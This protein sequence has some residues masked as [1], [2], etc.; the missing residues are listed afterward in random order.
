MRFDKNDSNYKKLIAT[1]EN[2]NVKFFIGAGLSRGSDLPCWEELIKSLAK[3]FSVDASAIEHIG[4]DNNSKGD[5]LQSI[6]DKI[7]EAAK[8]G[9]KKI[10]DEIRSE[11]KKVKPAGGFKVPIQQLVVSIAARTS[12]VVLTT[13][14]DD[15][16]EEAAKKEEI[17][18]KVHFY[19]NI[20]SKEVIGLIKRREKGDGKLHIIHMHGIIAGDKVVLSNKNYEEAY[21]ED[22]TALLTDLNYANI[23]FLGCSFTDPYF[24][25]KYRKEMG[26]GE[27]FAFMPDSTKEFNE[28]IKSQH[29]KPIRYIIDDKNSS[30][31]YNAKL[32]GFLNSLIDELGLYKLKEIR[33]LNDIE[34][35]KSNSS[36]KKCRVLESLKPLKWSFEG[37]SHIKEIECDTAIDYLP[38][39]AFRKC[40]ALKRVVFRGTIKSIADSAF[41]ECVKL[42][43]II[44][45]GK[46]NSFTEVTRI[47]DKAF[48]N[49]KKLIGLDFSV[50]SFSIV[51]KECFFHCDSLKIIE[52]PEYIGRIDERA[53][54]NCKSLIAFR[55]TWYNKLSHIGS[56]A[57]LDC[58]NLEAVVL[59]D[60]INEIEGGAF[61]SCEGI[62][63]LRIPK[64][65]TKVPAFCFHHCTG[66]EAVLNIENSNVTKIETQAFCGCRVLK[67][68]T[69]PASVKAIEKNAFLSCKELAHAYMPP[70]VTVDPDAFPE[71]TKQEKTI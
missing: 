13:N 63:V 12:G 65:L 25:T 41:E 1:L 42:E 60:N 56:Q 54:Y 10:I 47:G 4:P 30:D 57:F 64:N 44:V 22:L 59:G 32:D 3:T 15:L 11:F 18:W 14:Y 23:L 48:Y 51:P 35:L 71:H 50:S 58:D 53:F 17:E 27:W 29:I 26:S 20:T 16:L 31:E 62:V 34:E 67:K 24:V 66:I 46:I 36:I 28:Y 8:G 39:K 6:A 61:Q 70:H 7:E 69:F 21:G 68:I 40:S 37:I 9:D 52:L 19:P 5:I 49:C 38:S 55:F 43:E 2:N 33:G 45:N